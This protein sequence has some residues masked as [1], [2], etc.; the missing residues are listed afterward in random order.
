MAK[1]NRKARGAGQ[2]KSDKSAKAQSASQV[3]QTTAAAKKSGPG[4]VPARMMAGADRFLTLLGFFVLIAFSIWLVP[5]LGQRRGHAFE[6]AVADTEKLLR[7]PDAA[8]LYQ[9]LDPSVRSSRSEAEVRAWLNSLGVLGIK[10]S[11]VLA[12]QDLNGTGTAVIR[13]RQSDGQPGITTLK[14]IQARSLDLRSPWHLVDICRPDREARTL[15]QNFQKH[16][17]AN[18]TQQ[19]LALLQNPEPAPGEALLTSSKELLKPGT[20]WQELDAG[21]YPWVLA[22][23]S[24]TGPVYAQIVEQVDSCKLQLV[25]VST[26]AWDSPTQPASE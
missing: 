13:F 24:P 9:S 15:M 4:A 5:T 25:D 8:P 14:L 12:R 10:E 17:A 11:R 18:Q 2:A 3:S 23:K 6:T 21:R 1:H 19:A 7:Q 22:G 20:S 16:L 26:G